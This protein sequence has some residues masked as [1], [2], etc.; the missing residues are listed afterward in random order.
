MKHQPN[1]LREELKLAGATNAETKELLPLATSLKRLKDSKDSLSKGKLPRRH[2]NRW[3]IL[4]PIGIPS[5][6]SLALGMALV[7]LSQ[8]T[9]PGNLL[10]PVQK[11]SDNIS[12]SVDPNYRG[13]VMM[14]RAQQ[15][16]QLIAEHA[17]PNLVLAALA[18]Y[19]T[20]ALVYKSAS[21]NYAVYEYCKASL[22]QAA[23]IAPSSERQA[24]DTT[25]SSLSNV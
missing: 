20:E 16:K 3:K 19:Q 2:Q 6:M 17:S 25:L 18:D 24:I 4:W 23:A 9:L 12:M 15:V 7:I 1:N 22:R 10:Y 11:L 14:K 8:T 5:I 21:A 13:T